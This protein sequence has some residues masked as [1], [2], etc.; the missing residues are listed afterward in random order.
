MSRP[1][2]IS[3]AFTTL[4]S[5][6]RSSCAPNPRPCS[7]DAQP[8]P[9]RQRHRLHIHEV[10]GIPRRS[11][12]KATSKSLSTALSWPRPST[13]PTS[14]DANRCSTSK[15][16]PASASIKTAGTH[17]RLDPSRPRTPPAA[18]HGSDLEAR[19]RTPGKLREWAFSIRSQTAIC[20]GGELVDV[21]A[22]GG[23]H[24][25][26]PPGWEPRR[27]LHVS[28]TDLHPCC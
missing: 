7:D 25:C 27:V 2:P 23:G 10:L 14:Q 5:A 12:S 21:D 26:L 16:P 9:P 4:P 1:P 17:A 8:V 15:T 20:S 22:P 28:C 3:A 19:D 6:P 24:G 13:T 11:A 18:G